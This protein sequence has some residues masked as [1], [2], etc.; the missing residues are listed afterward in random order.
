MGFYQQFS[1]M[2][3]DHL[4]KLRRFIS[5]IDIAYQEK[6]KLKFFYDPNLINTL[7]SG[8]S[9]FIYGLGLKAGF[10]R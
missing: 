10:I 1:F 2:H 6:Q 4:D 5:F 3:D 7:Y 8:I 9:C